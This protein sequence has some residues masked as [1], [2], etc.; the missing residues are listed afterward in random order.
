[1]IGGKDVVRRKM[2]TRMMVAAFAAVVLACGCVNNDCSGT[3]PIWELFGAKLAEP[4]GGKLQL[5]DCGR[6]GADYVSEWLDDIEWYNVQTND[7]QLS[8]FCRRGY[9]Y[10]ASACNGVED[11]R[12]G[13]PFDG[14][15]G[16]MVAVIAD[17]STGM[18]LEV[19][20]CMSFSA[21]HHR[22]G[23]EDDCVR[24]NGGRLKTYLEGILGKPCGDRYLDKSANVSEKPKSGR[25]CH[26]YT[27]R[28]RYQI[29]RLSLWYDDGKDGFDGEVILDVFRTDMGVKPV[30]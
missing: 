10:H 1:M 22:R 3:L 24:K 29:I 27:W 28:K 5:N 16:W 17:K 6:G 18:I 20:G 30:E 2:N 8:R 25:Y 19:Y 12:R 4:W 7:V 14:K 11:P 21:H 9:Y 13:G 23:Y 15:G 26:Q